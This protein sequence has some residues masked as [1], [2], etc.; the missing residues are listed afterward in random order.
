MS[1]KQLLSRMMSAAGCLDSIESRP[2]W[3][4]C[5][6]ELADGATLAELEDVFEDADVAYNVWTVIHGRA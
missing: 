1:K 6:E 4:C 5:L 3:V 2:D